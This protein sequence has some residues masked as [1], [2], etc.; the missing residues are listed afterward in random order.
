[1]DVKETAIK[2]LQAGNYASSGEH[3]AV[4]HSNH[5]GCLI[6]DLEVRVLLKEHFG[7]D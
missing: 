7:S 4:K 2:I 6:T 5:S 1:M 3:T